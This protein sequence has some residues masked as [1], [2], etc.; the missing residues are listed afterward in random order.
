[1]LSWVECLVSAIITLCAMFASIR[2]K[3]YQKAKVRHYREIIAGAKRF[4]SIISRVHYINGEIFLRDS[5]FLSIEWNIIHMDSE[6][7]SRVRLFLEH[8]RDIEKAIRNFLNMASR[9]NTHAQRLLR[10]IRKKI[11]ELLN[12][13][14]GSRTEHINIDGACSAIIHG[15]YSGEFFV[16]KHASTSLTSSSNTLEVGSYPVAK[17]KKGASPGDIIDAIISVEKQIH[18]TYREA[19]DDINRSVEAIMNILRWIRQEVTDKVFK[20]YK[21]TGKLKGRCSE[22]PRFWRYVLGI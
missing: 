18:A 5:E 8:Y 7:S 3:R 22:C 12:E 14:M 2:Y 13:Y 19:I 9:H 16:K 1:M 11:I 20:Y 21:R 15:L 17:I 6:F 4:L 10:D